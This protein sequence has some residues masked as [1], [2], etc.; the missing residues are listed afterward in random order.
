MDSKI[1]YV[2]FDAANTLIYKPK[3][4]QGIQ[5]ALMEN[6]IHVSE[7]K[8]RYN[9]KL[10]SELISFP[11][12]TSKDFY[13]DFNSK[14]LYSIGVIPSGKILDSIFD[15]CSYLPWDKFED[16][17]VLNSFYLPIGILSNFNTSLNTLVDNLFG[18]NKFSNIIISENEK[19]AKP[20]LNFYNRVFDLIKYKPNDVLYIGDSI[21]LDMEPATKAGMNAFLIDR[22][23]YFINY[24]NRI[25]SLIELKE[26]LN[27]FL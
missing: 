12:R 20:S 23:N 3:L 25:G 21:K 11:D 17:Y 8:I 6:D 7:N 19:V 15:K 26:I 24:K 16:T 18:Y 5:D 13:K 4:W 9:H 2:L 14:L 27:K 1:K 22:D 10:L